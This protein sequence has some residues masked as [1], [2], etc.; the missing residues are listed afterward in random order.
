MALL[1][2]FRYG[3]RTILQ[4]PVATLVAV[5]ALALGIGVNISSFVA[6]N[7]M[8]LHP[9][10]FPHLERI[11]TIC[12]TVAK[13]PDERDA[14][15][16]SNFFLDWQR[17]TQ[18]FSQTAA[19]RGWAAS[20]TGTKDPVRVQAAQVSAAFFKVAGM[21]ASLGRT[22]TIDEDAKDSSEPIVVSQ[23]F[24]RQHFAGGSD[25]VGKQV[26]L[27]GHSYTVIGVMPD[28]FDFPLG[29]EIWTPLS[30][31]SP[32]Q[33]ERSDQSLQVIGLLKAGVS[34]E[35]A[36]AEA[37]EIARR[38]QREYPTTNQG[39]SMRVL[40]ILDGVNQDTDKFLFLLLCAASMVL[41]LACANVMN[42]QM[43]RAARRE[44]EIAV[45]AAFGASRFQIARQLAAESVLMALAGGVFA[46]LL[47][48]WNLDFNKARI[49]AEAFRIVP[50]LRTM[51][52]DGT[53]VAY[54]FGIS[55]VA[56]LLA[57]VPAIY[58]LLKRRSLTDLSEA[59]QAGGRTSDASASAGRNQLQAALIVFEV[60]MAMVLPHR[61][62]F[63][64]ERLQ[65]TFDWPLRLRGQQY[66]ALAGFTSGCEI[67]A[68]RTSSSVLRPSSGK[69]AGYSDSA[70]GSGVGG[71]VRMC[72]SA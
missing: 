18:S 39:R 14:V 10:P 19:Y 41:L 24:W 47:A 56:G 15:S 27:N 25:A 5:L 64:G 32:D 16:P 60:A 54:A 31:T 43:A 1:Q 38:L 17:Q 53:V 22:L 30:L 58:R 34:A 28:E 48:G 20:L 65:R 29:N 49:P 61:R 12:E 42:L 21:D 46:L 71:K 40:S 52:I 36:A 23:G 13:S 35:Q 26:S 7:A 3:L 33:S 51:Q 67:Y 62:H 50:G 4:S 63:N 59:L 70:G 8:V 6:V 45:R 9:F 37:A 66:L 55:I 2:D 68:G 44:K 11:M 57:C 69:V 72:E